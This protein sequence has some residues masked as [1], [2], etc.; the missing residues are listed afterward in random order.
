MAKAEG[1]KEPIN[2]QAVANMYAAMR[3]ELNQIIHQ[4]MNFGK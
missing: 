1:G 4:G 2:E 3:S